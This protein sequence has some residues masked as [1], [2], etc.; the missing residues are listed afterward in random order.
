MN[1]KYIV[2]NCPCFNE[3]HPDLDLF[4]ECL[5]LTQ[6]ENDCCAEVTNCLIKQVIELCKQKVEFCK[7]CSKHANVSIDCVECDER[8]EATLG[9][10][11]LQLFY[12][13]EADNDR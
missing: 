8:G 9:K 11:I 6:S 10:C 5:D 1:K 13:E 12:I 3:G 2:K 4:G 7:N